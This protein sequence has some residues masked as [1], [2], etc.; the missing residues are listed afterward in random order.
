MSSTIAVPIWLAVL[1]GVLALWA[2][3]ARLLIPSVRWIWTRR[4]NRLT[5]RINR[6]L[7]LKIPPL[8]R[9]KRDVLIARLTHDPKVL[10]AVA[11]HCEREQEPYAAVM[12]R[13]EGYAGEIVPAFSTYA[14]FKIGSS[15][16]KR[17]TRRLYRVRLGHAQYK[18]I[19]AIGTNASV[20]FVMNHRSNMD[21]LLIGY[22]A[23]KRMALSYAVGEWARVWPI[24]QIVRTLGGYFVRRGS[25]DALYRRVL[26]CYVQMAAEGGAVQAIFPEGGLSR[27][28]LLR[29]PKVGLLD[30]M[31]RNFDPRGERDI[32]F[33]PVAVNYDR[34]LEDRTLLLDTDADERKAGFA[35]VM[36]TLR[37]VGS[38][39][40]LILR[41]KWYRF[42]YACANF[43]EP[44]SLREYLAAHGWNPTQL[45]AASR[46]PHVKRL[47]ADLLMSVGRIVPVLPVSLIAKIFVDAP[48]QRFG[49]EEIK[50]RALKLQ[51]GYRALGAHVYIP[52]GNADYS[53]TVGLRMLTLRRI[54]NCEDGL[55]S[56]DPQHE[57]V[58]HYYANAIAHLHAAPSWAI[59][60]DRYLAESR[61]SR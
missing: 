37:F 4:I 17:F 3:F 24:Q 36:Q 9:T 57:N 61:H 16:A 22:L 43:G 18:R 32:V 11:A 38:Q 55:Y 33:V 19:R 28:G 8:A 59:A 30:Y 51:T 29:E 21:Y 56:A 1:A 13:V 20:V 10:R 35:A 6:R 14:Y 40:G 54:V 53:V 46:A 47:A 12:Q 44:I 34:V 48:G 25:G 42:G 2:A 23:S 49:E 5:E 45:D 7:A 58:L 27:D 39:L 60:S 50:A 26:E 41:R 52:R 31:V 15:L